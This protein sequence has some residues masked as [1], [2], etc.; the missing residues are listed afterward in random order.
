E[1]REGST[2]LVGV[3]GKRPGHGAVRQQ[4]SERAHDEK[5]GC[6]AEGVA[7]QQ[8]RSR[9]VDRL[10]RAEKQP[11][12]DRAAKGDE[13]DVPVAQVTRESCLGLRHEYPLSDCQKS[14]AALLTRGPKGV[15]FVPLA[16]GPSSA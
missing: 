3:G 1:A 6:A 8:R 15:T 14:P 7:R 4:L 2:E 11:D 12:P 5:D 13:L 9:I 16:G 10:G